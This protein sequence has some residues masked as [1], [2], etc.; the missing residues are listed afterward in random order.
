MIDEPVRL[1][2]L[3]PRLEA[4]P[5]IAMDTEADSLHAY[6]EKLCLLQFSHDGGDDLVDPLIGLNLKP[7]FKI[8]HPRELILHG[9]DYDLRLLRRTFNFVPSK[10]FDTMLAARLLGHTQFGLAHLITKNLDAQIEKGPQKMDWGRRPL[11]PRME[12]Y[13][14]NDTHFLKALSDLLRAELQTKGRLAWHE[15]TCA[16]LIEDCARVPDIDPDQLWR[17]KGSDR[18]DAKSLVYLRELWKWREEEAITANRP[19]YF[20]LSHEVLVHMARS[21]AHETTLASVIPKHIN[22]RRQRGIHNAVR[23]ASELPESEYPAPYKP[24]YYRST[25]EEQK[26]FNLIRKRRD[27]KAAELGID[28]TLIASKYILSSLA[29]DYPKALLDLMPWQKELLAEI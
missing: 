15:Q 22:P 12:A 14:R 11:T 23:K 17:I 20:I 26:A 8:L 2:A 24:S 6:P 18:L 27:A 25:T 28:P 29:R 5:W 1:A 4:S 10:I 3:L 19:P 16:R 13:A 9:A 21:A 7:L